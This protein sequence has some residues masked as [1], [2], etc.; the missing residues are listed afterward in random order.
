MTS[1][2]NQYSEE[3][4]TPKSLISQTGNE[5]ETVRTK[6]ED[7]SN[8]GVKIIESVLSILSGRDLTSV[9]QEIATRE[10][11]AFIHKTGVTLTDAEKK[12]ISAYNRI[13]KIS[14]QIDELDQQEKE[15]TLIM[16]QYISNDGYDPCC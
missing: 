6:R 15:L 7:L 14:K 1:I 2:T 12:C 11:V 10:S 5:L 8:E 3:M 9:Y 16:N 13:Q 4:M